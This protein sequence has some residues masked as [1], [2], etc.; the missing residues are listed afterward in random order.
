MPPHLPRLRALDLAAAWGLVRASRAA[1]SQRDERK[2][3]EALLEVSAAQQ[4]QA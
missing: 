1:S 3:Y 2:L 4:E